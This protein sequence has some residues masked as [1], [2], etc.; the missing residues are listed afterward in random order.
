MITRNYLVELP[1]EMGNLTLIQH[2]AV[3]SATIASN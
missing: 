1:H 3:R 2:D